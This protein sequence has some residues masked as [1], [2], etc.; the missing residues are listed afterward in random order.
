MQLG[1]IH[2]ILGTRPEAIKMAPVILRLRATAGIEC[3]VC[4]TASIGRCSGKCSKPLASFLMPI[5]T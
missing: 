2:V 1:S 5:W 3:R 4:A